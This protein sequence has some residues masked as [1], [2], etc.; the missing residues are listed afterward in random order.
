MEV[1]PPIPTPAQEAAVTAAIL[2]ETPSNYFAQCDGYG[3]PND[4]SD[5]MIQYLTS[6]IFIKNIWTG[7]FRDR[8]PFGEPHGIGACDAALTTL[9]QKYPQHWLRKT[10]LLRARAMHRLVIGDTVGA[11]KDLDAIDAAAVDRSDVFYQRSIK[12]G[13][14]LVRVYALRT[15]GRLAEG[16]TLAM[17]AWASRPYALDIAE[18]TL[19]AIGPD[20]SVENSEKLLRSFASYMPTAGDFLY[21]DAFEHGRYAEAVEIYPGIQPTPIPGDNSLQYR[22]TILLEEGNRALTEVFWALEGGRRA[23][24]LAALGRQDE[25]RAALKAARDRLNAAMAPSPALPDNASMDARTRA[26]IHDQTN[27]Q[28]RTSGEPVLDAWTTMVEARILVLEGK[29]EDAWAYLHK[30]NA[31]VA[32]NGPMAELLDS[33]GKLD[34]ARASYAADYMRRLIAARHSKPT[35]E[36]GALFDAL[37]EA[38]TR[39]RLPDYREDVT[40]GLFG[41]TVGFDENG[42]NLTPGNEAGVTTVKFRSRRATLQQLDELALLKAAEIARAAGKSGLVVVERRSIRHKI[43]AIPN[44]RGTGTPDGFEV[45]LDVMPIDAA[46]PPAKYQT[47]RWKILDANAVYSVL[48]PTYLQNSAGQGR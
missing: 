33:I 20:I 37:P 4:Q 7:V 39:G 19:T 30:P 5:G 41:K 46:V 34:P 1:V 43:N 16:Q 35:A 2:T 10:S 8:P 11:L 38:E 48:A 47:M 6:S 25:A 44:V 12:L 18:A 13:A 3:A 31:R 17:Q 42:F 29:P 21:R 9:D 40:N 22:D 15:S 28:L 32:N 45:Q 27:L 23:Y 36:L 24:A 26:A 14:D